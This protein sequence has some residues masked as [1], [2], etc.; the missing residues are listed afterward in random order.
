M[1]VL[2]YFLSLLFLV[3]SFIPIFSVSLVS[4]SFV[5]LL[6]S[7]P[8]IPLFKPSI[9][10]FIASFIIIFLSH[11]FSSSL[12]FPHQF[13]HSYFLDSIIFPFTHLFHSLPLLPIT[14]LFTVSHISFTFPL[15]H[16][17]LYPFTCTYQ[18]HYF[19]LP[20]SPLCNSSRT[21]PSSFFDSFLPFSLVSL[22]FIQ[23]AQELN[24]LKKSPLI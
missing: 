8:I 14:P 21:F 1:L 9:S 6:I 15:F 19:S 4:L 17:F 7:L 3:L 22:S 2:H 18:S 5:P 23:A 20:F 12:Y 16:L 13:P 10:Y 11:K 24:R